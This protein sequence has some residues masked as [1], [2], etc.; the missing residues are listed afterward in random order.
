M[1]QKAQKILDKISTGDTSNPTDQICIGF[2]SENN[3][4]ISMLGKQIS[5]NSALSEDNIIDVYKGDIKALEFMG[6]FLCHCLTASGENN[7]TI[8]S[9]FYMGVP[10]YTIEVDSSGG[11]IQFMLAIETEPWGLLIHIVKQKN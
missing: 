11:I 6:A 4:D 3:L 5:G 2:N 1:L 7:P 10:Y 8:Y 9:V